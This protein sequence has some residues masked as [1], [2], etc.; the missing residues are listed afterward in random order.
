MA[1]IAWKY[2]KPLSK[3]SAVEDFEKAKNVSFPLD[4]KE[5]IKTNNGGRPSLNIFDTDK[6]TGRVF[7]TLLSFNESDVE[8]I[9]IFFPIIRSQSNDLT[10]F[11]SDPFG[12][13]LCLKGNKIV[14]FLHE[15]EQLEYISDTF[16]DLLVK[17]HEQKKK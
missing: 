11:A 14:L 4:L 2:V 8:N 7:K 13:Y 10:P 17:L 12:N 5:C 15:T 1:E 3:T 16:S 9:Y 6:S